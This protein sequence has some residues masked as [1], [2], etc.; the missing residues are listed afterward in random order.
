MRKKRKC[1][2]ERLVPL[3]SYT[4]NNLNCAS[5][6]ADTALTE[7]SIKFIRGLVKCQSKTKLQHISDRPEIQLTAEWWGMIKPHTT[8]DGIFWLWNEKIQKNP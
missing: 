4:N 3:C 6:C 2:S 8:W 5:L 1:C 7:P